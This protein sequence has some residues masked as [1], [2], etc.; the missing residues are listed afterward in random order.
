M[1]RMQRAVQ[2]ARLQM[3]FLSGR[4]VLAA[5]SLAQAGNLSGFELAQSASSIDS[6][7][8]PF[9]TF[10]DHARHQQAEYPGSRIGRA[11]DYG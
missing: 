1:T 10:T 9:L 6:G 2:Q 3:F 5:N 7:R 4:M 11:V 8:C